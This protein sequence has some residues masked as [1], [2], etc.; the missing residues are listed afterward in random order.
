MLDVTIL[1]SGKPVP[2]IRIPDAPPAEDINNDLYLNLLG[3]KHHLAEHFGRKDRTII[4][5]DDYISPEP[6]SSMAGLFEP[7]LLIAFN[8]GPDLM[9]ACNGYVI[10]EQGKLPYFVLE[11]GSSITGWRV[12]GVKAGGVCRARHPG[13]LVL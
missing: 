9:A 1:P 8:V 2:F 7:D 4:I 5:G 13:I 11:I 10:S 3:N 6:T 12:P